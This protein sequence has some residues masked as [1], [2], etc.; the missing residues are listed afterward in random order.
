ML[1][2][3]NVTGVVISLEHPSVISSAYADDVSVVVKDN[4]IAAL[5]KCLDLFCCASS[6]KCNWK[7]SKALWVP[8]V[9]SKLLGMTQFPQVH[10][11][12]KLKWVD[13][14]VKYLGVF[15]W[16]LHNIARKTGMVFLNGW[17]KD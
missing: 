6:L 16:D 2:R 15:F 8:C 3:R 14:G 10:L 5:V 12:Q 1:L 11:P 7:K 17:K 9:K 4:D 13:E